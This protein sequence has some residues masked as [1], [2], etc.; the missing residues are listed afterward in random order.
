LSKKEAA[1]NKAVVND[2]T[3]QLVRQSPVVLLGALLTAPGGAT[4]ELKVARILGRNF[5]LILL[6]VMISALFWPT[7]NETEPSNK[8]RPNGF[9][10][11][12][13]YH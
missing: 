4:T 12:A 10:T 1:D 6:L 8:V 11:A 3:A 9:G 5:P 7:A 2:A 13:T